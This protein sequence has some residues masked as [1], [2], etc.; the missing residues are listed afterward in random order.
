MRAMTTPAFMSRTPGPESLPS[1]L[2]PFFHGMDLR[3]PWGQTVSR[4][5]RI[6]MGLRFE[7]RGP[8]RSS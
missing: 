5:P 4:W 8:K 2:S 6:R 3:V 7:V 1:L